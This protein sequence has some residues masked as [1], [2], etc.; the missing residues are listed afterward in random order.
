MDELKLTAQQ[1]LLVREATPA[2]LEVETTYHPGGGTPPRHFHPS[3]DEHFEVLEGEIHIRAD[4]QERV[5]RVGDT[6][7]VARGSAHQMWNAADD[8]ARVLW[9][10]R[11]AG[12]TE[13]W[14]RAIDALH[15]EGKVGGSGVPGPLAFAV[16]LAEYRDTFRLAVAPDVLLRPVVQLLA[17][18][19]RARGYD[20][21][22]PGD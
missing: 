5:L 8:P 15:R 14:F 4:D 18:L 16:M 6:V 1:S 9:Q 3:Q 11:P 7:D 12:R 20:P 10:T 19:G 13:D 17:L 2:L 21:H 22:P